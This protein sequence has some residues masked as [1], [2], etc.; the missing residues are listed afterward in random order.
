MK[1]GICSVYTLAAM[2][3]ALAH[4]ETAGSDLSES[5]YDMEHRFNVAKS[6]AFHLYA[7]N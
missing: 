3:L 5:K 6:I 7:F 2:V 1:R 4:F